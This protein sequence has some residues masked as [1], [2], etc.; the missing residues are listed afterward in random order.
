L[1]YLWY[2]AITILI[3]F[4]LF[5]VL[6]FRKSEFPRKKLLLYYLLS[7][8]LPLVIPY[9]WV[10]KIL[11][12][13]LAGL[14]SA[15]F[16]SL[17]LI[18]I[19]WALLFFLI[20]R[21]HKKAIDAPEE[22]FFLFLLLGLGFGMGKALRD[23]LLV[24]F[25]SLSVFYGYSQFANFPSFFYLLQKIMEAQIEVISAGLLG[26]AFLSPAGYT[27]QHLVS[28]SLLSFIPKGLITIAQVLIQ[29][30]PSLFFLASVYLVSLLPL[31][32]IIGAG[33]LWYLYR[34]R[35]YQIIEED[36]TSP[37]EENLKE[38]A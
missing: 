22:Q 33:L 11:F 16:I 20:V 31:T 5:V 29:F 28:Y 1:N 26:L 37:H 14:P 30:V 4:L 38:E 15:L 6:F 19:E 10:E 2:T 7:V 13:Y 36:E 27:F 21:V 34:R 23:T 12:D 25:H 17:V 18:L 3:A 32:L 24:Y 8:A 35:L 9:R